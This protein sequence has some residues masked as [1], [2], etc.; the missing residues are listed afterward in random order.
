MLL[1]LSVSLIAQQATTPPSDDNSDG[2]VLGASID[3]ASCNSA[4]ATAA[5]FKKV[6]SG[7]DFAAETCVK[8]EGFW[9]GRA[10]FRNAEDANAEFSNSSPRLSGRRIGIYGSER[11]LASAPKK[12]MLYTLVGK[13]RRCETAWPGAMMVMGYCHYTGGPFLIASEA[14]GPRENGS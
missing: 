14:I 9:S 8:V 6:A 13:L 1:C 2:I 12:P 5:P 11:L 4:N 7:A 3:P 10:I